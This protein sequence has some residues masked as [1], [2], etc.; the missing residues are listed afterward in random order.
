MA[1]AQVFRV[2]DVLDLI[3]GL[4]RDDLAWWE[5]QG[6]I[7][8]Q[9]FKKGRLWRRRYS[10][11]DIRKIKV[12]AKYVQ[13]GFKLAVAHE[14]AVKELGAYYGEG[15]SDKSPRADTGTPSLRNTDS[16]LDPQQVQKLLETNQLLLESLSQLRSDF[17]KF[18]AEH[19]TEHEELAECLQSGGAIRQGSS[20]V[21]DLLEEGSKDS[22]NLRGIIAEVITSKERG[23]GPINAVKNYLDENPSKKTRGLLINISGYMS[24]APYKN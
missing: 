1:E 21:A 15:T 4:T 14:K 22:R 10:E 20:S 2:G 5:S 9:K 16:Q 3:P 23:F 17:S 7:T 12:I 6:Y 8:P 24:E 19:R 11:E 13:Q 18:R